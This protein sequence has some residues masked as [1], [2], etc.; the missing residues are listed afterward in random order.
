MGISFRI[1]SREGETFA[2]RRDVEVSHRNP[3][4]NSLGAAGSQIRHPEF[5]RPEGARTL[6]AHQI[7]QPFS[8]GRKNGTGTYTRNSKTRHTGKTFSGDLAVTL[9]VV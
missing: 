1:Q 4:Q 6:L 7:K 5:S 9:G 3:W 8:V 2:I